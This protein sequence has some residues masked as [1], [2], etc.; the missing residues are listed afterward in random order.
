[1]TA[2][3]VIIAVNIGQSKLFRFEQKENLT[4]EK[5]N[6]KDK[7]LKQKWIVGALVGTMAIT[8]AAMLSGCDSENAAATPQPGVEQSDGDLVVGQS[9]GS[10]E[11]P[12]ERDQDN[13]WVEE[14][15]LSQTGDNNETS[16]DAERRD[17]F[18]EWW[19]EYAPID[20]MSSGLYKEVL[21]VKSVT[22]D[23]DVVTVTI[24]ARRLDNDEIVT[25]KAPN[26]IDFLSGT[27]MTW[28]AEH[29]GK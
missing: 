9:D 28:E 16:P 1:L 22:V 2:L 20:V 25:I 18:V 15:D 8:G 19:T 7:T 21:G 10:H 27:F 5:Q 4:M 23:G 14:Q 26:P 6:D 3:P 12:T 17:R 24:S 11:M 29:Y 13:E